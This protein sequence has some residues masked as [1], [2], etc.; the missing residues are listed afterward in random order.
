MAAA[1]R[2]LEAAAIAV[3]FQRE[4]FRTALRE[5]ELETARN[6]I[7]AVFLSEV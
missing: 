3:R 6:A 4:A 1:K 5:Q 2:Q 7:T